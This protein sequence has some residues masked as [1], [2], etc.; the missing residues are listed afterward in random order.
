[1][2]LSAENPG[3]ETPALAALGRLVVKSGVSLGGLAPSERAQVF[4]L[5][6]TALP[7]A[8]V[9]E[10]GVNAHLL[11]QLEGVV[12][13]LATDHVELR[14]WLVDAGWLRRDAY[15]HAYRRTAQDDLAPAHRELADQWVGLDGPAW[16][17][18]QRQRH[19]ERRSARRQAWQQGQV[20]AR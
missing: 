7:D 18:E 5:V 12:S 15:G 16:A 10:R 20:Q 1:M 4:A 2:S 17:R 13:F 3:R 11:A 6:W 19:D 8:A 9:S 14:R